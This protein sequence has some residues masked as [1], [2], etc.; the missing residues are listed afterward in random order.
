MR[1]HPIDEDVDAR[2]GKARIFFHS[3]PHFV[4]NAFNN[5]RDIR[6]VRN[7]EMEINNKLICVEP[8]AHTMLFRIAP[9]PKYT[10]V[11]SRS[12]LTSWMSRLF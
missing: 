6:A 8:N 10:S 9:Q 11:L 1:F 12:S 7:Y 4:C 5:G 2:D 3:K